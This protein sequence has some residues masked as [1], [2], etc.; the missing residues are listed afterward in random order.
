MGTRHL[1]AVVV[2]GDYK[3]AQYGQWDGYLSG[4]GTEIAKFIQRNL[5]NMDTLKQNILAST[6][7]SKEG[8]QKALASVGSVDGW[9][10]SEQSEKWNSQYP[11]LSRD[12]GSKILNYLLIK[13]RELRDDIEFAADSLFCEFGYVLDLDRNV[14]E[15]YRGFN[16]E[17]LTDNDRFQFLSGN[18]EDSD[19]EPIKLLKELKFSA[20]I[21]K[22]LED[23]DKKLN[24]EDEE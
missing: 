16:K 9:M 17:Q 14:L 4:Q 21:L 7:L 20:N 10:N 18:H 6:F 15:I 22:E 2:N 13:P 23:L 3:V 19:Y 8:F 5:Q 1:I 24:Q 11:H 12:C